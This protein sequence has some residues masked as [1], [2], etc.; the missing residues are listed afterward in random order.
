MPVRVGSNEG[1]GVGGVARR[2]GTAEEQ[3]TK[4]CAHSGAEPGN[5]IPHRTLNGRQ[6]HDWY[7]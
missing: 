5:R 6:H 2:R 4:E 3:L 7:E 1:L